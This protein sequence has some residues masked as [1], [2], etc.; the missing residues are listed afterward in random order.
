MEK[1]RK[2]VRDI[3]REEVELR[4]AKGHIAVLVV[5]NGEVQKKS[6]EHFAKRSRVADCEGAYWDSRSPQ[7]RNPEK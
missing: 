2:K 5:R 7:W 4:T 6:P 1:F 3:S